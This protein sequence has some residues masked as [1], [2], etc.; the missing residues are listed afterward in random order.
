MRGDSI[1]AGKICIYALIQELLASGNTIQS[2]G[3]VD[4]Y[5]D[6]QSAF[7]FA[8]AKSQDTAKRFAIT[9]AP[10]LSDEKGWHLRGISQA[11][12]HKRI[13]LVSETHA[14]TYTYP[15]KKAVFKI[16]D[17]GHVMKDYD[18][19]SNG[20]EMIE[21]LGG[22]RME[23][24]FKMA[25]PDHIY[26][27]RWPGE[28]KDING[29]SSL[30]YDIKSQVNLNAV[31]DPSGILQITSVLAEVIRSHPEGMMLW[32]LQYY[33]I[34]PDIFIVD[35]ARADKG[36]IQVQRT[37]LS[38][39]VPNSISISTNENKI[40]IACKD[41]H[42]FGLRL[43]ATGRQT[44]TLGEVSVDLVLKK[45]PLPAKKYIV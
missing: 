45:S 27:P 21:I 18:Y 29:E 26:I 32:L 15:R 2:T 19:L 17:I 7:A 12:S 25:T 40:T 43:Y 38:E 33:N 8:S 24:P 41:G 16:K 35:P 4:D 9:F 14:I 23:D 11:F 28:I 31:A 37:E 34:Y 39:H 22:L 20:T 10:L 6:L 13:Y 36:I 1:E 3:S 42:A 30:F 5:Y 44:H